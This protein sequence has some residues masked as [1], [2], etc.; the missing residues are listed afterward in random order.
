MASRMYFRS[1]RQIY[2]EARE[3]TTESRRLIKQPDCHVTYFHV[4][5]QAVKG[6]VTPTRVLK[7]RGFFLSVAGKDRGNIDTLTWQEE[8]YTLA[9][10]AR[11]AGEIEQRVGKQ[12]LIITVS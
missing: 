7:E 11:L 3:A 8:E 1:G 6:N 2:P 5:E 12:D 10:Y 4:A 9:F